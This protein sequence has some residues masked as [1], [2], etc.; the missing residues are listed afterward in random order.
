VR[1]VLAALQPLFLGAAAVMVCFKKRKRGGR[2]G[3][4]RSAICTCNQTGGLRARPM[5]DHYGGLNKNI[6]RIVKDTY[7]WTQM[8]ASPSLVK[9][10]HV[11]QKGRGRLPVELCLEPSAWSCRGHTPILPCTRSSS[12]R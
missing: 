6:R 11:T 9:A 10:A 8:A 1:L 2:R 7:H 4:V 3:G 12:R 5:P